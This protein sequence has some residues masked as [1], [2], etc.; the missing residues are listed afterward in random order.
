MT[1]KE[2]IHFFEDMVKNCYNLTFWEY[3]KDLNHIDIL[4]E[5][6]ELMAYFLTLVLRKKI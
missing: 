1:K 5:D 6:I 2:R 4:T 3:D